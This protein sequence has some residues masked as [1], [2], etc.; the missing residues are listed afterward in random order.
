LKYIKQL[1]LTPFLLFLVACGD[2]PNATT[3]ETTQKVY[4]KNDPIV[5]NYTNMSGQEHD[6]IGI[7]PIDVASVW[8]NQLD[9]IWT[10]GKIEGEQSF[11]SLPY[12]EYEVRAFFNNSF[13]AKA[14]YRFKID[15]EYNPN[16]ATSISLNKETYA[17][18]EL[19]YVQYKNMQGNQADQIGLFPLN[20]NQAIDLKSTNGR[21]SGELSLGG[22]DVLPDT[23]NATGGLKA[24]EYE[25]KAFFNGS[26]QVES[27]AQF[28]IVNRNVNS[29][30]YESGEGVLSDNWRHVAGPVPPYLASGMVNLTSDWINASTN[31]SDYRLVFD[32]PNRQQKVLELDAGGLRYQKHFYIGVI[33]QTQHGVRKMIWDPFFS[34]EKVEAFKEEQYLSYPL[35]VDIQENSETRKHVR[36]DVDKYL[37][38]LEPNNKVLAISAFIASGGDLDDIKLSSH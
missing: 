29:T 2:S 37:R 9:W 11:A 31:T 19:I 12:G 34:H 6:W 18:N 25:V 14:Q 28:N 32:E 15:D 17:Q 23:L 33:A 1:L 22:L 26:S 38:L 5:V 4:A 8:G 20:S 35:Y 30:L 16:T 24:G 21:V 27:I 36:V 13:D 3:I 7:Y 10:Q